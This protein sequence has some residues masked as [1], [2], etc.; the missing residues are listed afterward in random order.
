[1]PDNTEVKILEELNTLMTTCGY[2]VYE[3]FEEIKLYTRTESWG[4]DM[5][6]DHYVGG[7]KPREWEFYDNSDER[8]NT[9]QQL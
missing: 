9:A 2:P 3:S 1:M 5:P 8:Y 7:C 6:Y 4:S